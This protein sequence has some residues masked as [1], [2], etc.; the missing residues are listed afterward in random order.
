MKVYLIVNEF[1]ECVVSFSEKQFALDFIVKFNLKNCKVKTLI[2]DEQLLK[3]QNNQTLYKVEFR[4]NLDIY[5]K[6]IKTT[7]GKT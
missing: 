4:K 6:N 1:R 5:C 3:L 7:K 2:I